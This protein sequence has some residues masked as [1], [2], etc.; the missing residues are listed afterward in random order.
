M[1]LLLAFFDSMAIEKGEETGTDL[2][3]CHPTSGFSPTKLRFSPIV[4]R[5]GSVYDL[6]EEFGPIMHSIEISG[7][8][9]TSGGPASSIF[10]C[11]RPQGSG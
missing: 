11:Q 2:E 8:S 1:G 4:S 7:W 9:A 10:S 6:V 5:V 3:R